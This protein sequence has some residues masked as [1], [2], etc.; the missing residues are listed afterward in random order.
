MLCFCRVRSM[1]HK[2]TKPGTD[3]PAHHALIRWMDNLHSTIKAHS[4][5]VS[6]IAVNVLTKLMLLTLQVAMTASGLRDMGIRPPADV[7]AAFCGSIPRHVPQMQAIDVSNALYALA[8]WLEPEVGV[9]GN[10]LCVSG[11]YLFL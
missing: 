7:L 11:G 3:M 4:L 10:L 9:S 2:Y 5:C 1:L 8:Y 6:M